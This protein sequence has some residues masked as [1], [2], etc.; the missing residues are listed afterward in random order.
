[1]WKCDWCE[2]ERDDDDIDYEVGGDRICELCHDAGDFYE[3]DL[4]FDFDDEEEDED[5]W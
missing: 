1:M 5:D 3:D 4:V 2:Q